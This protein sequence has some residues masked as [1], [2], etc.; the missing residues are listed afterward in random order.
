MAASSNKIY[1]YSPS[2]RAYDR[3]FGEPLLDENGNPAEIYQTL[4]TVEPHYNR[5]QHRFT[6]ELKPFTPFHATYVSI[7]AYY[8]SH[9]EYCSLSDRGI[10]YQLFAK[11]VDCTPPKRTFLGVTGGDIAIELPNSQ[12]V[13]L[14]KIEQVPP[15]GT[16]KKYQLTK[17]YLAPE[18]QRLLKHESVQCKLFGSWVL[19]YFE[20]TIYATPGE[21]QRG[22][23]LFK[24]RRA[25]YLEKKEEQERLLAYGA[26]KNYS[27]FAA[28]R[29]EEQRLAAISEKQANDVFRNL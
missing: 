4:G 21:F 3:P 22:V 27:K 7:G 8:S 24:A 14:L 13:S 6:Y 19:D 17:A 1:H 2:L 10:C 23:E 15:Y 26:A 29:Q 16:T 12:R 5:A 18:L 28:E 20:V 9:E 11:V 25:E